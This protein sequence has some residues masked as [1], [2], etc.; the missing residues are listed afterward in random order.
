M[1][2]WSGS[3]DFQINTPPVINPMTSPD[4]SGTPLITWNALPG[5][6]RYDV[7]VNNPSTVETA[8]IRDTNVLTNSYQVN[9]SFGLATY[10]IWV[11]AFDVAGTA[12]GWSSFVSFTSAAR[13]KSIG[14]SVP[15]FATRPVFS[16]NA[17]SGARRYEISIQNRRTGAVVLSV[18]NITT[19]T[20]TSTTLAAN[21]YRWWVRGTSASGIVGG[22]SPQMDF[23]VGGKPILL[24]TNGTTADRTP[25]ITWTNVIGAARYEIWVSRVD[26]GVAVIRQSGLTST[27]L[28][29]STDFI[30]G[31][32]YRIWVRAVSTTGTI[33]A[34]SQFVDLTVTAVDD[35]SQWPT[36]SMEL[37]GD[38]LLVTSLELSPTLDRFIRP[39][40]SAVPVPEE[41]LCACAKRQVPGPVH[42]SSRS[43]IETTSADVAQPTE[44][45][46]LSLPDADLYGADLID[47]VMSE[48]PETT[49]L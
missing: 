10:R 38:Q 49:E 29:P 35:P 43:H 13:V 28:T 8:V 27:S 44:S 48:W 34:W 40:P 6:V 2:A 5:A 16:W 17:L 47:T 11:R 23:S 9:S 25:T 18:K 45:P 46:T 12:T 42:S 36:S 39:T 21:D 19:T 22:W 1:S 32:T 37:L 41:P 26:T 3:R 30:A 7:D 4:Y 20:W 14:P 15:T 33:S 31:K 24:M